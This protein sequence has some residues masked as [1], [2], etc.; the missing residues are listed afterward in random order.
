LRPS[1]AVLHLLLLQVVEGSFSGLEMAQSEG[2]RRL[3]GSINSSLMDA[4]SALQ[5]GQ[6]GGGGWPA[7][8]EGGGVKNCCACGLSVAA[9]RWGW[10]GGGWQQLWV[11]VLVVFMPEIKVK[12]SFR[13]HTRLRYQCGKGVSRG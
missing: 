13:F 3:S 7:Q 4:E 2:L 11:H 1:L 5:V 9:V 8:G 12:G 10:G 6:G